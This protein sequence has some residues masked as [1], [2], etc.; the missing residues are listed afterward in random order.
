MGCSTRGLWVHESGVWEIDEG[1]DQNKQRL[2]KVN[3]D[4]SMTP[5]SAPKMLN[6]GTFARQKGGRTPKGY[7]WDAI[8]GLGVHVSTGGRRRRGGGYVS[9]TSEKMNE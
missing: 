2:C 1:P 5:A 8:R 9:M 6:D 7:E 3:S 4:G